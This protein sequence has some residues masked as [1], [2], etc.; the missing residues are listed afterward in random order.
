VIEA[1]TSNLQ[2]RKR[3]NEEIE[4][5][6]I[7]TALAARNIQIYHQTARGV[8]VIDLYEKFFS[9]FSLLLILTSDLAQMRKSPEAVAKAMSWIQSKQNLEGDKNMLARLQSGFDVFMAYKKVLSEQGV[10]SLPSR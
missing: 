8:S 6:F 10:I 4:R 7:F 9:E 2:E 3:L 1:S 5:T